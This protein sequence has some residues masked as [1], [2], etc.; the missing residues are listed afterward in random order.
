MDKIIFENKTHILK[1]LKECIENN[2]LNIILTGVI[3]NG[4]IKECIKP[5]NIPESNV[6]FVDCFNDINIL[7]D[8]NP[9]AIHSKKTSKFKKVIV[10]LNF[11]NVSEYI[12]ANFKTY[13]NSNTFFIFCSDSINKI[14]ESIV[15][16]TTHIV[17][18]PNSHENLILYLRS[19]SGNLDISNIDL[20][21]LKHTTFDTIDNIINYVK[22]L[23]DISITDEHI[24]ELHL[25]KNNNIMEYIKL[26]KLKNI[27][28]I[29][30]LYK[31]YELG[32]SLL[33]IYFFI[34]EYV[35]ISMVTEFGFEII[36]IV[37]YYINEIYEG[38]D[39]KLMLVFLTSD[40]INNETNI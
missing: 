13:M 30:I 23:G 9:I 31:Y 33:D 36:N 7:S 34:Y 19:N 22:L 20:D 5:L 21:L 35:K 39:Y 37:S 24:H 25:F 11:D 26:V 27:D 8:N 2:N 14:Y 38:H 16:R 17:F 10:I 1:Q 32:Y 29:Q 6:I 12:Q 4:F 18:K 28:A 15:T 40:I 3:P